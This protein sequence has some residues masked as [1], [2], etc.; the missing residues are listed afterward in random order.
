MRNLAMKVRHFDL[1]AIHQPNR[2]DASARE[3]RR[4]RR[5]QASSAD[6]KNSSLFQS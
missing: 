3:V 6:E 4:S 1:I 5:S 2:P